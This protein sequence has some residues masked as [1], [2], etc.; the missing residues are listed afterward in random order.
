MAVEEKITLQTAKM[1]NA[2]APRSFDRAA[3]N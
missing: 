2:H 1:F 3:S